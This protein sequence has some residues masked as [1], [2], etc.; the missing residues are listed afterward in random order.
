MW[1]FADFGGNSWILEILDLNCPHIIAWTSQSESGVL[2]KNPAV[3]WKHWKWGAWGYHFERPKGDETWLPRPSHAWL[4]IPRK[5]TWN[6][7]NSRC[8]RVVCPSQKDDPFRFQPMFNHLQSKQLQSLTWWKSTQP[9]SIKEIKGRSPPQ[10]NT[11]PPKK[12]PALLRGF[13]WGMMLVNINSTHH[14]FICCQASILQEID[15]WTRNRPWKIPM[16]PTKSVSL[17]R[18]GHGTGR[19]RWVFREVL[20]FFG[21]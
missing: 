15:W 4:S 8:A 9:T 17:G 18:G 19:L 16:P 14:V 20:G 10:F 12:L 13:L 6:P 5:L 21:M 7:K 1:Y 11:T 2:Q 3:H